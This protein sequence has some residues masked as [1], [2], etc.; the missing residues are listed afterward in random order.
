[1]LRGRE[2]EL[3][4]LERGIAGGLEGQG[5]THALVGEPGIGKTSL[6]AEA[7]TRAS[8]R[9]VRVA[10]GRAWE[11]GGAAAYWPWRQLMASLPATAEI[12]RLA[13]RWGRSGASESSSADPATSR[14]EL[15]EAVVVAL[16]VATEREPLMCVF[17]DL[18]AADTASLEL[19]AFLLH[20]RRLGRCTWLLTWRDAEADR[21]RVRDVIASIA[22]EA[23]VLPL[24][25][26]SE[27]DAASLALDTLGTADP[28]TLSTLFRA[29]SGNPLFLVEVLRSLA[30]RGG[31]AEVLSL[32][33]VPVTQGV[34]L[35]VR[36]R[37]R[38]LA[39]KAL[40]VLEAGAILG[41]E[42][43]LSGVA[44]VSGEPPASAR[45]Q[46]EALCA[47]GFIRPRGI[48][49]WSFNHALVRDALYRSLGPDRRRELHL[50]FAAAL[51]ARIDLGQPG[52]AR[53]RAHHGLNAFPLALAAQV[54]RW[55]IAAA[56]EARAQCA[57]EDAVAILESTRAQLSGDEGA[58]AEL[59]VAL[60]WAHG[61]AGRTLGMRESLHQAMRLA[62]K[63][64]DARLF[65][66]AVLGY[67]SRYVLGDTRAD[68]LLLLDEAEAALS[69]EPGALH[70][71]L[72]ARRAAA[73]TPATDTDAEPILDMARA[74]LREVA[75]ETDRRAF[76]D[77]AVAA[78][79]AFGDFAEPAERIAVNTRLVSAAREENDH[80]LELR[81][82]GR[83]VTD[84]L[85]AGD[86]ARADATLGE[87]TVR[88]DRVRHPR[89][90]WMAPLF[91][92]M[93]AQVRGAF[94]DVKAAVDEAVSL[95]A[96]ANDENARRCIAVHRHWVYLLQDDVAALCAHE[97]EVLAAMGAPLATLAATVRVSVLSR[98]DALESMR[99]ELLRSIPLSLSGNQST[100]ALMTLGDA[101][102]PLGPTPHS[103]AVRERLSRRSGS[104]AVWGLFGF[105]CGPP[106]RLVLGQLAEAD[107]KIDEA[108][109]SFA[110]ALARTQAMEAPAHEAWV[111]YRWG[112]ALARRTG[113]ATAA[114]D[115]LQR[116]E[117][118]TD[119]LEM[120]G[121]AKRVRAAK[122][123]SP[124]PLISHSPP[125]SAG[126]IFTL[127]REGEGWRVTRDERRS[128]VRDI[129]GMRMLAQLVLR[130]NEE[131]H[132]LELT[133]RA[134][135]GEVIDAGDAGEVLD[136]AA[137][138]AY[139]RRARMLSEALDEA[140]ELG[141]VAGVERIQTE[142]EALAR[143]LSR[144]S[145]LGGRKR[146]SGV[147]AERARVVVQRRVREAIRRIAQVDGDLGH[148]LEAC[149]RTGIFCSY[150]P[151]RSKKPSS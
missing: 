17:D 8:Q 43:D 40:Q 121:L 75:N 56:T 12:A 53:L 21:P 58:E 147:A 84:Y 133:S 62:K 100:N 13:E 36:E 27:T 144:A 23:T 22:R 69:G 42:L 110:A 114:G 19:L 6:A 111:R 59:L 24:R 85:E 76:I 7:S 124:R 141:D 134:E 31:D 108:D 79:S 112:A 89:F 135:P 68:L 73:L 46:A 118:L 34:E 4:E 18:H 96:I 104:N 139:R 63:L 38:H 91:R 80:V 65:A 14:E 72:L 33:H 148:H 44:D 101:I 9:G 41:R 74:A 26:L 48:D 92:S 107:A 15:F 70:A 88:C 60:G 16:S 28:T 122:A 1:M 115:H 90:V 81:G 87:W 32:E 82:L 78:G 50:R 30:L 77:V 149:V 93:R 143:E 37:S 151:L 109:A 39:A 71:R 11:A 54:A 142:L 5:R 49:A 45:E 95:A 2:H 20:G 106:T 29:T 113:K 25:R 103:H 146:R 52:L 64:G 120:P 105:A 102:A 150:A 119:R 86:V 129:R 127:E 51:D 140:R 116:A 98:R 10:W 99:T 83:L 123:Q 145:G 61:D 137:R 125:P 130:P 66:R 97:P 131:L 132:S 128:Y 136:D 67:G 47:A 3:R 35:V 94:R 126:M 117:E 138:A 55:A 57:Y